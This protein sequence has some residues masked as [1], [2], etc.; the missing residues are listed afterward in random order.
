MV[1]VAE[2][3]G[4]ETMLLVVM[5]ATEADAED[6]VWPLSDAGVGSRAQMGKVHRAS[7]AARDTAAMRLDPPPVPRPHPLHRYAY[8][9]LR[10]L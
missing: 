5:R 10:P 2:R 3:V 4:A 6:V 8:P 1:L 9:Q 7:V